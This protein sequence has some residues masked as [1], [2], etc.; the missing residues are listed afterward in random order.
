MPQ[1]WFDP[2]LASQKKQLWTSIDPSFDMPSLK[3]P[4]LLSFLGIVPVRLIALSSW[5]FQT[6]PQNQLVRFV[7]RYPSKAQNILYNIYTT[8]AQRYTNVLC[9]LG[10]T[11]LCS[12]TTTHLG[13]HYTRSR[14]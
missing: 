5:I 6:H 7:L 3:D 1:T 12:A 2:E 11:P 8:S 10:W 14:I 4:E 13:K 9:L